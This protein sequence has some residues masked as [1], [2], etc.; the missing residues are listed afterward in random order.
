MKSKH[1]LAAVAALVAGGAHAQATTEI[2]GRINLSVE[3][4]DTDGDKHSG[5]FDNSSRIGFRGHEDLGG[6]LKV[7]FVLEHG[8]NADT[9]AA[10]TSSNAVGAFWGR[11]STLSISGGF[12]TFRFGNMP[13]SEAYFA[14]A[15]YVSMHNHDTGSSADALYG[16]VAVGQ[17]TS[18]IAYTSPTV[19]GLRL[20]VQYG[21]KE[22]VR[23]AP[24]S[25]A[26][27]YDAGALHLGLGYED[28]DGNK[29]TA[30]RALYEMGDITVGGYYEKGSGDTRYNNFRV[31]GMYTMGASEFHLNYGKRGDT[32]DISGTDADQFTAGYNYNLSKRTKLY[33]FYTKLSVGSADFSSIALGVRHNF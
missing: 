4:Q 1:I 16:F 19:N 21:M 29:S 17:L 9:G 28:F 33:G 30:L 20:D 8:F 26:V 7:G 14:T 25:M 31:S 3:R 24:L 23:D 15:D 2:Y 11:E 10:S 27:N 6:G 18:T 32:N 22:G 5:L 13:A 12:G